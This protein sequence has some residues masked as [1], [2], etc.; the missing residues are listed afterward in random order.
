MSVVW[1]FFNE[2]L[3]RPLFNLLLVLITLL[4]GN[5]WWGIVMLTLIIRFA[6]YNNTASTMHMQQ[7]TGV[8]IQ[9]KMEEIQK[10]YADDPQRQATEMMNLLKKD[11]LWPLKWCKALLIQ[12]PIF[13]GLYGVISNF[14]THGDP[15]AQQSRLSFN[16][17][18]TEQVYSFL[19]SFV[20]KYLDVVQVDKWFLGMDMFAKGNWILAVLTVIL[21]SIQMRITMSLRPMQMPN[22]PNPTGQQ[23]P[24][25]TKM[26]K[27]MMYM[28]GFMMGA[29]VY[30]TAA[31]I[32]VYIVTTTLFWLCQT[33]WTNRALLVA[34]YRSW[35]AK[36]TWQ[37]EIIDPENKI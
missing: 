25:M 36:K 15:T 8:D 30:G 37:G 24:D 3:F 23:M 10:R 4:G 1:I 9:K 21:M 27:P 33:A 19:S 35:Y 34:K 18:Y 7:S 14:A 2:L 17:P 6:L 12:I 20:G 28:M 11:G 29:V 31:G 22:V 16:L 32:G 5:M 26:M 13:L